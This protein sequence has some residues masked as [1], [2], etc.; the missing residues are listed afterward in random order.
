MTSK[1]C[2]HYNKVSTSFISFKLCA[3][4]IDVNTIIF[5]NAINV[6]N[7]VSTSNL[8]SKYCLKNTMLSMLQI[9]SHHFNSDKNRIDVEV[10]FLEERGYTG[11]S[12]SKLFNKN[13]SHTE[14]QKT[15]LD[16]TLIGLNMHHNS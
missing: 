9:W 1:N 5:F 6:V 15:G 2:S 7:T 10:I 8:M 13:G 12:T 4:L 16:I 3:Q 14:T 11:Q